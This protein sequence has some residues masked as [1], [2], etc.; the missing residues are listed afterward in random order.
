MLLYN[1]RIGPNHKATT[2][3]QLRD[4]DPNLWCL[5]ARYY[6]INNKFTPC[7]AGPTISDVAQTVDCKATLIA[8]GVTTF[9]PEGSNGAKFGGAKTDSSAIVSSSAACNAG[10]T[11]AGHP[12]GGGY[13][14][15]PTAPSVSV[16]GEKKPQSKNDIQDSQDGDFEVQQC[17]EEGEGCCDIVD[18]S[19]ELQVPAEINDIGV[20]NGATFKGCKNLK[21]LWFDDG[22]QLQ[23][24]GESVFAGT[25]LS[26]VELPP[27]LWD[28]GDDGGY[29]KSGFA[30]PTVCP[31]YSV[32]KNMCSG[33]DDMF[34]E[35][36]MGTEVIE[37]DCKPHL[38]ASNSTVCVLNKTKS[39]LSLA[40]DCSKYCRSPVVQYPS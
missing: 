1:T 31:G 9:G 4:N 15:T 10:T 2:R 3:T 23:Q 30:F 24:I 25:S 32:C 40:I 37:E 7:P 39:S 33:M 5:A 8:L 35:C 14:V 6:E 20:T 38:W 26:T 16:S 21:S 28:L 19:G 11:C 29:M 34:G 12:N 27:N 36:K 17:Y 22:S 13:P 18:A